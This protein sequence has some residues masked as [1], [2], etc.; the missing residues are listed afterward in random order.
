[1]KQLTVER[2]SLSSVDFMGIADCAGLEIAG[3]EI[4]GQRRGVG[5]VGLEFD[6]LEI[7]GLQRTAN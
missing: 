3:L 4:D 1:M 2:Q 5:I 7:E 6:G